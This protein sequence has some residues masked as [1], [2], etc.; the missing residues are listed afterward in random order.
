MAMSSHSQFK[1][2]KGIEKTEYMAFLILMNCD[3]KSKKQKACLYIIILLL[4][5][6][7]K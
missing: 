4:L 1:K 5:F 7:N 6:M 3:I 2:E